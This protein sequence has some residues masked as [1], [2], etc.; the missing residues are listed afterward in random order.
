MQWLAD[1]SAALSVALNA[2]MLVVW[3]SYLNIFL[4]SFL[5]QRRQLVTI[6]QGAGAA[7][8]GRCF[9][10]NLGLEPIYIVEVV[11]D[12]VVAGE[13]C[14]AVVTDRTLMSDQELQD[15][16]ETTNQGPLQSGHHSSIGEFGDLIRRGLSS[17]EC[18]GTLDEVSE[19]TVTVVTATAAKGAVTGA[20]RAF[21][22]EGSGQ[23]QIL[24]G[25]TLMAEQITGRAAS[26]KLR[27]D[28]EKRLGIR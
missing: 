12:L 21:V 16:R 27:R 3:I 8:K 14:Q 25:R 26:R 5:R 23:D 22:I 19:V 9:V 11:I 20:R 24:H 6:T 10:S 13:Q 18:N 15:P 4:F 17:S 2:A 28:L 7:L 1:H